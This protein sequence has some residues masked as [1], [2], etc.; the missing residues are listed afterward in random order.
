MASSNCKIKHCSV[1]NYSQDNS[2]IEANEL[3]SRNYG[4]K[5]PYIVSDCDEELLILIEF[6]KLTSVQNIIIYAPNI[7]VNDIKNEYITNIEILLNTVCGLNQTQWIQTVKKAAVHRN[8]DYAHALKCVRGK[9]AEYYDMNPGQKIALKHLIALLIYCNYDVLQFK[10]TETYRKLSSQET[11]DSMK[12]RHTNYFFIG[13]LLRECVECFGMKRPTEMN[14]RNMMTWG[15]DH[16]NVYHGVSKQFQFSSTFPYIKCPLST[17]TDYCVAANFCMNKGMI[18]GLNIRNQEWAISYN[19]AEHDS[20]K[21]SLRPMQRLSCFD[22]QWISDYTN[23]QEIFCIGGMRQFRFDTIITASK[24][25]NYKMYIRGLNQM[26]NNM[27]RGDCWYQAMN[28]PKTSDEKQM[29]FR[30][31]SHELWRNNPNHAKAIEF[32]SCPVYIENLLHSTC[33]CVRSMTF[34]NDEIMSVDKFM[35]SFWRYKNKFVNLELIFS[36]FPKIQSIYYGAREMDIEII[37]QP[38]IYHSVLSY[39]QQNRMEIKCKYV[40]E[41]NSYIELYATDFDKYSWKIFVNTEGSGNE[42]HKAFLYMTS[43]E[44]LV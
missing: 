20:A 13:K 1:L 44:F 14:L 7:D 3:F 5:I 42:M 23:E 17:T 15:K 12:K 39:I 16:I 24:C 4:H 36:V 18:L 33:L 32:K 25:I 6:E 35:D 19:D 28:Y 21:N 2:T 31:I 37:K 29:V 41:M 40:E 27:S 43:K 9:S 34:E 10:F 8:T 38:S 26:T 30:L 11:I 22:M